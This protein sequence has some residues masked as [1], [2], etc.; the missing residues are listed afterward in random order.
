MT[1][2]SQACTQMLLMKRS[3]YCQ[4]QSFTDANYAD[5]DLSMKTKSDYAHGNLR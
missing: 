4:S 5:N 1:K 2:K 3:I